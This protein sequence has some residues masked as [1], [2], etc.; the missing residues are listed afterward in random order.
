[1]T[2]SCRERFRSELNSVQYEAV[3][4]DEGPLLVIAGAGSGKTRTLTYRAARLV[5]EGVAPEQILLLT[6][7]R[8]AADE[9]LRRAARLLDNRCRHIAGGTFHSFA[10]TVLK[11]YAAA[12]GFANN[13]TIIDRPDAESLI[14]MLI[15]ARMSGP[16][17]GAFPRKKT[18]AD[19]FS[20][21]AN[22]NLPLEDILY[23]E[24]PHFTPYSDDIHALQADYVAAKFD[25]AFM[26]Y[27][28]LL[29]K[30][31]QLMEDQ[32][33]I[34]NRIADQFSHLMVDEYQD[35]NYIQ[36]RIVYHLADRH[37]RIMVVGDDSQ[38]IYSFRGANFRNIMDFPD[39]FPDTRVLT[40]EENYRSVVPIL[41]LTNQLIEQAVEKYP[42]QLFS[43]RPSEN[44]PCLVH[45][46]SENSQSRYIVDKIRALGRDGIPYNEIAV[47]FRA[48]FHAFDLEVELAREGIAFVKYGGFKFM[49]SA[50]IK[51]VLAHMRI[52][53]NPYDRL[54]WFRILLLINKVGPKSAQR[55]YADVVSQAKGLQGFI[56][57]KP[58]K[59]VNPGLE[60]L[61]ALFRETGGFDLHPIECGERILTYY[62]PILKDRYDD[63]PK[64]LRHLEQLLNLLEK[65][66]HLEA[67]L[68][69]MTLEPPNV[70][71]E[72]TFD[73]GNTQ[74]DRLVLSTVHSAKGLEWHTV[75][76]IWA[77]DGRFPSYMASES[78]E[79][80]DEELRL[81]YVA[82][83]RARE[84]LFFM[85][86]GQVFDRVSGMILSRP[87][88]FIDSL[89]ED[90]LV[91]QA[92][93]IW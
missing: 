7:T 48:G 2:P 23:E 40:L 53:T 69:D 16:Q 78:P 50:H 35:T 38:S 76:I 6:F 88:R 46:G 42:K 75:F 82:A 31:L 11:R 25:Q 89:P 71:V 12:L 17:R 90:L 79:E 5:E 30:L 63:H 62:H 24:Y 81:M 43:S 33:D 1:M 36:A 72:N 21:A 4:H 19:I 41:D 65:Y 9:M 93:D 15:K 39:L 92:A 91:R 74:E 66:E 37:Q 58:S 57:M 54:S 52:Q 64:R 73:T 61:R 22:K 28:D 68:S 55:I 14:G 32:P 83:T 13:F 47:L 51:D 8:K 10:Y 34:K 18:L 26:D 3:F 87:S 59:R 45:T 84:N 67:F 80:L 49:E 27:D 77:M 85:C 86:P 70:A 60:G 20:R 56:D 29:T 44:P